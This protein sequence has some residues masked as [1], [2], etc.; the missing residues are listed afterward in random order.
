MNG[1]EYKITGLGFLQT[2]ISRMANNSFYIKGWVLTLFLAIIVLKKETS[3][4]SC[5]LETSIILVTLLFCFL[6]AY[7]LQQEK[8]FRGLYNYL[9]ESEKEDENFLNIN[10]KS[11]KYNNVKDIKSPYIKSFKSP[12]IW[13]FYIAIIAS[14]ILIF[15][16]L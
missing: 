9:S 8:I 4:S 15:H 2:I 14:T 11:E 10:P 13:L 7:Y 16:F 5:T 3:Y 12:S 1:L 6:D